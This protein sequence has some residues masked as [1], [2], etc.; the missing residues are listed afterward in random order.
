MKKRLLTAIGSVCFAMLSFAQTS[1]PASWGFSTTTLP[2]G[3]SSSGGFTY[4]AASGNPAPS[5]KFQA[6]GDKLTIFCSSSP[7]AVTYDIIG[8]NTG[9]A[10]LGTFIT[11]ESVDGISW[12]TMHTLTGLAATYT[13]VTD[14]PSTN[15]R[16][17]RFNFSNKV[18]G[19][20]VGLD[21][22]SIA[23][24]VS[25]TQQINVKQGSTTIT[26]GGT[27]SLSSPVGT[28]TPTTFTIYNIGTMGTCGSRCKV[29][30]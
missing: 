19:N 23:A 17:I 1:L 8:N 14:V 30:H 16:Y 25:T 7:G 28:N 3:W 15:S 9:G 22:V 10:W 4:Y 13:S 27:Y 18:S 29:D 24:G 21:N 5:A 26:N 20:N 12:T 2:T 11:E 6:T